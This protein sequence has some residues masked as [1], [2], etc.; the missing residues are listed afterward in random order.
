MYLPDYHGGSIVNLMSSI[1]RAFGGK[2]P[3]QE[4]KILSSKE[5]KK[6]R[7]V[8]LVVIDGLGYEYLK[9]QVNKSKLNNYL[10][11]SMT[12]VFLPTTACAVTTFLTGVA[13]QQHAF[14]GWFMLLKEIGIVSKIL[15][16]SPRFGGKPFSSEGFDIKKVLDQQAF[17]KRIKS[18][19]YSINHR[20]IAYS[21]FTKR[22]SENS[23][24]LAY[25]SLN[26]FFSKI[27]K[28]IR[29]GK[30]K[31][32]IYAYWPEFDSLSHKYGAYHKKSNRHFLEIDR[33]I[34][35]L[36]KDLRGTNTLL[37]ITADH[38]SIT[39]PLTRIIKLEDHPK[40]NECLSLPL[41]GEGRV[42]YCYVHPDKTKQFEDYVNKNL[43]K[44]CYLFRSQE[45]IDRHFFGLFSSNPKLRDKIGDY[46][47]ILKEDYIIKDKIKNEKKEPHI[48]HHGGVSREEMF[49]PLILIKV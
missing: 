10:R 9:D 37:I 38:G 33:K 28:A 39:T 23:K 22:M 30:E 36:V 26:G 18:R 27:K 44:Y 42:A 12:S 31:K 25:N 21:D 41:C 14:T 29:S 32:Y 48:G 49:V 47:L 24:I 11:G 16:F 43:N 45:L 1:A 3:Y 4:L 2:T 8:A 40:M 5:I 46:V 34:D 7:N 13:P 19:N 15:P 6:F 35:N 17:F 20:D